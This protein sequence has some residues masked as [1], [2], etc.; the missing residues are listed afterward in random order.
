MGSKTAAKIVTD[1]PFI[2]KK[3]P[4]TTGPHGRVHGLHKR[5]HRESPRTPKQTKKTASSMYP[6]STVPKIYR[7]DT[8]PPLPGPRSANAKSAPFPFRPR[9]NHSFFCSHINHCSGVG[10][11][12]APST[13]HTQH[14]HRSQSA[15]ASPI[16]TTRVRGELIP[17]H[18]GRPPPKKKC[19]GET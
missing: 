10:G 13:K 11:I 3:N 5:H 17:P 15:Q 9:L 6:K 19:G 7:C 8:Q 2:Y 14:T 4:D 1:A 16:S 12:F 18:D